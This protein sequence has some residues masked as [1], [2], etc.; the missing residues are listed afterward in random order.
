MKL[1]VK[2]VKDYNLLTVFA[3]IVADPQACDFIKKRLQHSF[4]QMK[5]DFFKRSNSNNLFEV[6]PAMPLTQSNL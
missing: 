4:F 5:F 6:I 3:K 2:I 1:F